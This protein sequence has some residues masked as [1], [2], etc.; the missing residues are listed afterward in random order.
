LNDIR[1]NLFVVLHNVTGVNR[2]IDMSQVVYGLGYQ[3][4]V[5]SRAEGSAA[6]TGI[7]E[8]NRLALKMKRNF[9]VLPD[10]GDV[11]ELLGVKRPFLMPSPLLTK[12]R[13]SVSELARSLRSG[14]RVVLVLSGSSSSFSRREMDL[15]EC[16]SLD[17][18]VDIGP[19]GTAA[20]VLYG[21]SRELN[22]GLQ[23]G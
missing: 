2:I 9:I 10:L 20:V 21:L 1:N 3:N 11:V 4:F 12:E 8:A 6:Q 22:S 15:G 18:E 7:P 19:S 17:T 23:G 16:R 14:E 5:V 13:I